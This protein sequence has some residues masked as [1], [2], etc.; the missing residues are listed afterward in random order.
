MVEACRSRPGSLG[1][2]VGEGG[3]I[4]S[5][6]A[7]LYSMAAPDVAW[8]YDDCHDV[9]EQLLTERVPVD[10]GETGVA[11]VEA[12]TVLHDRDLGPTAAPLFARFPD[13]RR[14]GARPASPAL[15]AELSGTNLVGADVRISLVGDQPVYDLP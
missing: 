9:E 6:S 15:A 14:T 3:L 13:G 11:T 7:G 1:A 10:L 8:R 5:F 2:V 12:M 4:A